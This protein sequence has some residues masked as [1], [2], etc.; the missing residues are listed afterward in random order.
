MTALP[1]IVYNL[2]PNNLGGGTFTVKGDIYTWQ[3]CK[4]GGEWEHIIN[5]VTK[6]TINIVCRG[7]HGA[8]ELWGVDARSF[9]NR[10][11]SV[12]R[13]TRDKNDE[14][15]YSP[16]HAARI[17]ES[18]SADWDALGRERFDPTKHSRQGRASYKLAECGKEWRT[19]LSERGKKDA[20]IAHVEL[21]FRL[22]ILPILGDIDIR[23]LVED[24]I[25]RLQRELRKKETIGENS[26]KGCLQNLRTLLKRY[27]ERKHVITRLPAFPEGWSASVFVERHEVTVPEQRHLMARLVMS[28]PKPVRKTMLL[29]QKVY[30]TL[31]CRPGEAHGLR[32]EDILEDGR[33]KIQGAIDPKTGLFGARKT[34]DART[35][36]EP[37]PADLLAELR[38]LPVIGR[39][40]LFLN[41]D[42]KPFNQNRTSDRFKDICD[43]SGV[44]YYTYSK[45]SLASRLARGNAEERKDRAAKVVGVTKRILDGH[46]NLGR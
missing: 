45:H 15:I 12:G 2:S 32:R 23:E 31:G 24:D 21:N 35:T 30:T 8:P 10:K 34:K 33:V 27:C 29:L 6:R 9:K 39:G 25:E 38:A 46:Y 1:D 4:C 17:L 22:H 3:R 11:G 40:H 28:Y 41:E 20:T 18:I 16:H 42:G 36:P 5:S 13:V 43:V 37:L 19:N 26:V 14:P 7:C 44:T